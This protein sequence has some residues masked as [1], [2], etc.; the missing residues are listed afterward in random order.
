[1]AVTVESK[2]CATGPL[3]PKLPQHGGPVLLIE[4]VACINEE[5]LPVLLLRVL[6]LDQLHCM[7]T[8]LYPRLDA[9]EATT[10]LLFPAGLFGLH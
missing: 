3:M 6:I 2:L 8:P 7:Y 5:K 10:E 9:P 4:L 1:M